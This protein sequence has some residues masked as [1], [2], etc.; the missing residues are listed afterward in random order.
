MSFDN[1]LKSWQN[2]IGYVAQ[3]TFLF[4]DS[5]LNNV[6]LK[7]FKDEN[8]KEKA[9]KA[10]KDAGLEK[11][12]EKLDKGLDTILGDDGSKIS[13]GQKQRIGIARAIFHDPEVYIFDEI[14]SSLDKSSERKII[15]NLT[16]LK[17]K[18]TVILITHNPDNLSI[19]DYVIEMKNE[20]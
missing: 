13:G 18:K 2:N 6:T 20:K 16:K 8:Y 14:T 19:C 12:I 3:Q 11:F 15:K 4:N 1:I 9:I 5:I 10:L 7:N 17:S